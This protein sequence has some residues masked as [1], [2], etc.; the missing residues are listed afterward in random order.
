MRVL[1]EAISG[2]LELRPLLSQ[3]LRHACDLI[4]AQVGTIGL[5]DEARD[6]VRTEAAFNM[7]PNEIGA[8]MG[9]GVGVA[10]TV[11]ATGRP[12][13]I[14]RYGDLP[15]PTQ[16]GLLDHEVIG[17]PIV[18]GEKM[19]G[20]FGLG[21]PAP[22][23]DDRGE[24]RPPRFTR[25]DMTTLRVFA[26]HAAVA[27][28]NARRYADERRRIERLELIA[29]VG[30][31]VTANLQ[32][33]DLLQKAADALHEVLG[34]PNIAIPLIEPGDP[35]TLVL[36][37]VGGAYKHIVVGEYRLPI[38]T[39]LM[40]AA[41]RSCEVV[42]VND[43]E[44]DPR[45][46][47]TPGAQG[48]T[49]ELAVPILLGDRCLGIVNV[50]S[51]EPFGDLDTMGLRIV[52]GQLAVAIENARLYAST[53]HLAVVEERRRIAREL[54]DAVTQSLFSI[55]LIAQ[56]LGDAYRADPAD[57][58][59][60]VARLVE[61][62][63]A[64]H[65]ELRALLAEL[66]PTG[67]DPTRM[68]DSSTDGVVRSPGVAQI[69]CEGLPAALRAHIA[70]AGI[71]GP[72]IHLVDGGYRRQPLD[73]EWA[74]FRIAQEALHNAMKHARASRVEVSLT[75]EA[76]GASRLT[77][78]DDG[79]GLPFDRPAAGR[80][81][82]LGLDSMRERAVAAGGALRLDSA[83]GIGLRVVVELPAADSA[84]V[85]RTGEQAIGG[86]A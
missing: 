33:E 11:L 10:G 56:T 35:N 12:L 73:R 74:L 68:E 26:R 79:V 81:R 52:A 41:A 80:G 24:V 71:G 31:L 42:L 50:E 30:R 3:I 86:V 7:P 83:P 69:E 8:E 29:H 2:E 4:G 59:R 9:R 20:F 34:Y 47:P 55:T 21:L 61:L 13:H 45:Y 66:R 38:T 58:D 84:S 44:S 17:M 51:S 46:V 28:V 40:G 75:S 43:V 16:L 19:I 36:R 82:G 60:R 14:Q 27:I 63:S 37:T 57:G 1:V 64:A 15:R 22:L 32:L 70:G 77:I 62:G 78:A 18:W 76:D 54:H 25:R 65:E 48:I 53:R 67:D 39:G 72:I 23:R 85:T 49:A 5:V 6:V